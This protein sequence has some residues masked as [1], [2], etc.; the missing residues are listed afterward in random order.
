MKREGSF[1]VSQIVSD[2]SY[3]TISQYNV[4]VYQ[5]SVHNTWI[6]Q[7]KY[8]VYQQ[9]VWYII[10]GYLNVSIMSINKVYDI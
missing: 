3:L 5:L 1:N 6:S 9:G 4:H 2:I 7:C 10:H 8:H